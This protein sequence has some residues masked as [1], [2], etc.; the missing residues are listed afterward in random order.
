M[1][2]SDTERIDPNY[3]ADH[4]DHFALEHAAAVDEL[5]RYRTALRGVLG[6][7]EEAGTG[8]HGLIEVDPDQIRA[9][10]TDVDE[11]LDPR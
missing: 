9:N 8:W 7:L 4:P 1:T 10:L 6:E 3:I 2:A 11:E 5:K